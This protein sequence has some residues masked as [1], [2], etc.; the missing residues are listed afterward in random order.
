MLQLLV[1]LA[2][3]ADRS[4]P[5]YVGCPVRRSI[6]A[7]SPACVAIVAAV[8]GCSS[9]DHD[10]L[11]ARDWPSSGG[12]A[13]A[14]AA[15]SEA[16]G[17]KADA[18]RDA[19]RDVPTDTFPEA[20]PEVGEGGIYP[21]GPSVLTFLNGLADAPAIRVCFHARSGGASFAPLPV[22]PLPDAATG[23]VYA[24]AFRAASPPGG[25]DLASA[26]VRPVVYSGD[27]SAIGALDCVSLATPAAGLV[28]T[29]LPVLPAGTLNKGRSVLLVA[30]GCVGG[31]GHDD[32]AAVS[33]CG[34]GYTSTTPTATL[35]V[36]TMTR[37]PVDGH[38][39]MQAF[40]GS[41]PSQALTLEHITPDAF[42]ST[43]AYDVAVGTISPKPPH[44]NLS[45]ALLG[46][47]P[48]ENRLRVSEKGQIVPV[49]SVKLA[50]ALA[51]GD[52]ALG[53]FVNGRAYT[54]VWVGARPGLAPGKWWTG[55][56]IALVRSDP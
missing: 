11:A 35:L 5:R 27:M 38:I 24:H 43:I 20:W 32:A 4:D 50:D 28:A 29:S 51:L 45:E 39:S 46:P 25:I 15:A 56:A 40:A 2:P 53:D 13:G 22:A 19:P 33:A 3:V 10:A 30:A 8:A 41:L 49:A 18:P 52:L 42:A 54:A 26:D 1:G 7:H 47:Q 55:F 21:D 17:P 36:A 44:T 6:V 23:L 16:A 14:D 48:A 12:A 37:A 34:Q 9:P 31:S